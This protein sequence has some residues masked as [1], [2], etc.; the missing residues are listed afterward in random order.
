MSSNGSEVAISVRDVAKKYRLYDT[1]AD[2]LRE[3]FHPMRRSYHREFW[4]LNGVSFNVLRGETVGIVGRNGSG[5][6]TLLQLVASV[7]RPTTGSVAVHGRVTALLA[8]GAGFNP[9]FSG[10]DNVAMNGA[11]LGLSAKEMAERMPFVEQFA[12]IGDYFDQPVR[13]YSSGMFVRLAFAAAISVDPE[14][15]IIDEALAVGDVRFQQRCYARLEELRNKGATILLVS[16][17]TQAIV[18]HCDRAILLEGGRIE[19]EGAPADVIHKYLELLYLPTGMVP[20]N[21]A[22]SAARDGTDDAVADF[23]TGTS[24]ADVAAS[25]RCYN[26]YEHRYGDGRAS[27][28]DF[29]VVADGEVDPNSVRSGAIVELFIKICYRIDVATPMH[30]FAIKAADGVVLYGNNTVSMVAS[31]QPAQAGETRVVRFCFHM[32]FAAMDVFIDLGC[33]ENRIDG[34]QPLDRRYCAIHLRC[35]NAATQSGFVEVGCTF[36]TVSCLPPTTMQ[37]EKS[38]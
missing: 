17:D 24:P 19:A 10:R 30:G 2:R 22:P 36:D 28:V 5:K 15:I 31:V 1:N 27:I 7:A 34:H 18:K 38:A 25:R 6:S 12:D 35:T 14:I 21:G 23:L 20:A 11:I 9:D 3:A 8:L 33:G 37:N 13:T 4:A 16:H 29:L 32:P 26:A